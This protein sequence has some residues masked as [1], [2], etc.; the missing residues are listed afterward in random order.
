MFSRLGAILF[1]FAFFVG[2]TACKANWTVV[3]LNVSARSDG[4]PSGSAIGY[5]VGGGTQELSSY[6]HKGCWDELYN[7]FTGAAGQILGGCSVY[8]S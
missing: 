8:V 3:T 6:L 5:L 7:E 4:P 2:L 1:T